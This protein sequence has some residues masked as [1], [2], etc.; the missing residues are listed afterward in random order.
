MKSENVILNVPS[1][2]DEK[3][4][5]TIRKKNE[6]NILSAAEAEFAANGFKGA[7]MNRIA[8]RANLPKSNI[9]YYF[10]SKLQLYSEVLSRIVELWD[11]ALNDLDSNEEPAES[12]RRY[13]E[14]KMQLS[15]D[16]PLASRVFAKEI[17]SGGPRLKKY[18]NHEY[19][20]W[21]ERKTA[22]FKEW[23]RQ[24]KIQPLDPAHIIF[25]LWS[26]TQHYA[27]FAVQMAAAMG[28]DALTDED[29]DKATATVAGIIIRGIG[30]DN[31]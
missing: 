7:T 17:L 30:A 16:Y 31:H 27:D 28:Q 20:E 1:H 23:A 8:E 11:S 14:V 25:M 21:F 15:R 4:T 26:A 22:V 5:G 13:V 10:G 2:Q 12:L 9:H 18:F 6:H 24:G 19:S 3:P 29:F